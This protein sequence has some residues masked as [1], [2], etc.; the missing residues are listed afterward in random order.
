MDRNGKPIDM[1]PVDKGPE[2]V[3]ASLEKWVH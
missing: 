2:A 3:A 1:L